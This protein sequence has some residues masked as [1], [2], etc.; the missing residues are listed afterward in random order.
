M[1]KRPNS[2]TGAYAGKEKIGI[3]LALLALIA[4][5]SGSC[6]LFLYYSAHF[7]TS[8][9]CKEVDIV[10]S[11]IEIWQED[12]ESPYIETE[13]EDS[14]EGGI[15]RYEYYKSD[16]SWSEAFQ[17]AIDAGG[18]L[19]RINSKEEYDYIAKQLSGSGFDGMVLFHIGGR[20]DPGTNE[21]YWVDE[22]NS[23]YGNCINSPE[24]WA[25]GYCWLENEPSYSDSYDNK[26]IEEDKMSLYKVNDQ[27]SFN[28]SADDIVS[29]YSKYT[30]K[31]GY[32]IEYED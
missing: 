25:S 20:R 13:T 16:C 29:W 28:D 2:Q 3:M 18:Y 19:A 17:R 26:T 12:E 11:N 9:Y 30:G 5:G 24:Y 10:R 6:M 32:I 23:L 1:N 15:H 31:I 14:S 7:A 22:E 21:Y 8:H 4:A 27:W